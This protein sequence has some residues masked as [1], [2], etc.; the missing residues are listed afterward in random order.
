MNPWITHRLRNLINLRER[1][2]FL[3]GFRVF[4]LAQ[5]ECLFCFSSLNIFSC[6]CVFVQLASLVSLTTLA[7][8]CHKEIREKGKNQSHDRGWRRRHNRP[9]WMIKIKTT[10]ITKKDERNWCLFIIEQKKSIAIGEARAHFANVFIYL[11]TQFANW[12]CPC[13]DQPSQVSTYVPMSIPYENRTV[14]Y[15][16]ERKTCL[17]RVPNGHGI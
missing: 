11:G 16:K 2:V 12:R 10:K 17:C 3:D 8:S 14:C 13:K 4:T 9:S 15:S 6:V 5:F 7:T 1:K